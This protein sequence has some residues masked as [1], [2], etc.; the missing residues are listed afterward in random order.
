MKE[1]VEVKREPIKEVAVK[2][3]AEEVDYGEDEFD[4]EDGSVDKP[5]E[6]GEV[7]EDVPGKEELKQEKEEHKEA[8]KSKEED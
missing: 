8:R 5:M 2:A 3:E 4:F 6:T 7:E 1:E